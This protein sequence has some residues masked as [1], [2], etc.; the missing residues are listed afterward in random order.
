[1]GSEAGAEAIAN[2]SKGIFSGPTD[3][4]VR[5]GQLGLYDTDSAYN[6]LGGGGCLLMGGR[7]LLS[8]TMQLGAG[9]RAQRGSIVDGDDSWGLGFLVSQND[10]LLYEAA[11]FD[12]NAQLGLNVTSPDER[13]DVDGRITMSE[14][15]ADPST[16][17]GKTTIYS[18]TDNELIAKDSSGNL[19]TIATFDGWNNLTLQNSW[20]TFGS[21]TPQYTKRSDE[22]VWVHGSVANGTTTDGTV[23]ATLPVGYRPSIVERT[24]N[25]GF[26]TP[27]S[28]YHIL[29][30]VQTNGEIQY[31]GLGNT[32]N[33]VVNISIEFAI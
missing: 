15:E 14:G 19:S 30:L 1:V 2:P 29:I 10:N 13:L 23:I 8:G 6:V 25:F 12:R 18:N 31:F 26:Q 9:I 32:P 5:K 7:Y 3:I 22:T 17:T 20:V 4:S 28:N 33:T 11:R 24:M 16:H 27:S 21:E